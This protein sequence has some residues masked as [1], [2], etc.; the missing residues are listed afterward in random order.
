M[1][2]YAIV[3]DKYSARVYIVKARRRALS[4]HAASQGGNLHRFRGGSTC[5]ASAKR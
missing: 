4:D 5:F 1:K 2:I 3:V